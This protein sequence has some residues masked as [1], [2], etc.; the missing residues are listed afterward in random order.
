MFWKFV[1]GEEGRDLVKYG[2]G[3]DG[4]MEKDRFKEAL[5]HGTHAFPVAVYH[6][7]FDR[8]CRDLAYLHYHNEFE[9]LVA[10]KGRM[11]VQ[12]EDTV[13]SLAEGE[14][15]F[16]HSGLLHTITAEDD[17][18]H[19]FIAVV[20]DFSMICSEYEASFFKYVNPLLHGDLEV[21][22]RLTDEMCAMVGEICSMY[23]ASSFGF[24]LFVKYSL[25]HILY[26]LIKRSEKITLPVQNPKS[27]L[28]KKTL[29]FIEKHYA[30]QI[31][32]K[33]MADDVH[34]SK[35]YLCRV[36]KSMSDVSPIMFLNRYRI[37]QS[38]DLLVH[39][40]KSISDISVSCGFNNSS[41]FDKMFLRFHGCTPSEY[42]KHSSS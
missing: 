2:R 16:I 12:I 40:D 34:V 7:F 17:A 9:L 6:N 35:E 26:Q 4:I 42:R 1:C 32:L 31:S 39:T 8:Q 14:G 21:P 25:T 29:D 36:F 10:V 23:E 19:E 3:V 5:V 22:V 15:L 13:Y 20:F 18:M 37:K 24:E 41:Y 38:A 28:V 30:E 33:D 27:V 11:T